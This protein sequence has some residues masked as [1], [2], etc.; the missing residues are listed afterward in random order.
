MKKFKVTW[1]SP[2]GYSEERF[3]ESINEV[4]KLMRGVFGYISLYG[5]TIS[6]FTIKT[7]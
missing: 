4:V 3:C 5:F 1:I 2:S 7:I 6:N